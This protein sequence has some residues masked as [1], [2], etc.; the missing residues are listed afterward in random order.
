MKLKGGR[1][2]RRKGAKDGIIVYKP[3]HF[4]I[5]RSFDRPNAPAIES[6]FLFYHED[7]HCDFV[8]YNIH[9]Y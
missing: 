1:G 6:A 5:I 7:V 3:R 8:H 9:V 4:R 2:E